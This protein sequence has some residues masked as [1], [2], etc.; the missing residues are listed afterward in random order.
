MSE[1]YIDC[2]FSRLAMITSTNL[3]PSLF[4]LRALLEHEQPIPRVKCRVLPVPD[5]G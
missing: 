4:F 5:S 1:E 2:G 3:V